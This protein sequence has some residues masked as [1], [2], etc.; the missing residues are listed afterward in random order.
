MHTG[1]TSAYLPVDF[2]TPPVLCCF[3]WCAAAPPLSPDEELEELV[4]VDFWTPPVLC[5][6]VSCGFFAEV[7]DFVVFEVVVLVVPDFAAWF[8][9]DVS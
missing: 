1:K 7:P 6:A 2:S 5:L 3:V 9:F 4:P 8:A